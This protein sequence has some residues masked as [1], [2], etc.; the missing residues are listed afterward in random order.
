M[1]TYNHR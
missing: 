1:I